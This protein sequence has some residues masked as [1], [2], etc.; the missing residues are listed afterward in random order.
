MRSRLRALVRE[1][2]FHLIGRKIQHHPDA[3][4]WPHLYAAA[5]VV[6][7]ITRSRS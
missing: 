7:V 5:R 3:L 1:R 6:E 2:L 4:N